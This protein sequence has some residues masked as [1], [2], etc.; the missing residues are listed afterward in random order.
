MVV[1][2][3]YVEG[4]EPSAKSVT[5]FVLLNARTYKPGG[6]TVVK[7]AIA[8]PGKPVIPIRIL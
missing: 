7:R 3:V 4:F 6:I 8:S 1:E 2:L 5:N